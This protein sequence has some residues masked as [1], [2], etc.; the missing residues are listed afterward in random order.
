MGAGALGG[1][2]CGCLIAAGGAHGV[3][4]PVHRTAYAALHPF[5]DGRPV[6]G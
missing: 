5:I 4:S 3:P 1:S 2:F 6:V